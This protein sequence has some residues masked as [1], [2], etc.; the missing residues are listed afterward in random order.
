[1]IESAAAI[2]SQIANC[3]TTILTFI[4][5]HCPLINTC[6]RSHDHFYVYMILHRIY[7]HNW[8]WNC[9]LGDHILVLGI[10]SSLIVPKDTLWS[11][12]QT[13][14]A[15]PLPIEAFRIGLMSPQFPLFWKKVALS[16]ISFL[17][18]TSPT[19]LGY[20]NRIPAGLTSN[21]APAGYISLVE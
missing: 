10:S 18:T 5:A 8:R 16:P 14:G 17:E 4:L 7:N 12:L 6:T 1:M 11:F 19:I 20:Q 2:W 21:P 13:S 3:E 9:H 15:P